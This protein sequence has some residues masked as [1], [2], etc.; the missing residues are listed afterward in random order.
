MSPNVWGIK[1]AARQHGIESIGTVVT[2]CQMQGIR[3]MQAYPF[4][5]RFIADKIISRYLLYGK[6]PNGFI[7]YFY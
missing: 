2:P 3:K 4:S 5:T 6:L 1:E 7:R